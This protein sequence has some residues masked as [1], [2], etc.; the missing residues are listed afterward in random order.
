MDGKKNMN[1]AQSVAENIINRAKLARIAILELQRRAGVGNTT[2]PPLEKQQERRLL[3]GHGRKAFLSA[4][5]DAER[6]NAEWEKR[7]QAG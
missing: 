6:E 3:S 2:I 1:E 4:L 5:I 7:M